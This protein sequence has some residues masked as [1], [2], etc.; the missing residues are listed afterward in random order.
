M[1]TERPG[2]GGHVL[3]INDTQE[4]L[5][6]F[7]ALLEEEGYRVSLDTF[8][9]ADIR[10]KVADIEAMAPDVIVLDYMFG[11]EPLGWQLLQLLRMRHQTAHVPIVVC[12]A[13][14]KSAEEMGPHLRTIGVEVVIKPFEID[15]MLSAVARALQ[16]TGRPDVPGTPPTPSE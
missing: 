15:A 4:I 6:A 9:A 14:A 5:D 11:S 2:H 8:D 3:V 13:A 16:P 10:K 7:R 1:G 12:T